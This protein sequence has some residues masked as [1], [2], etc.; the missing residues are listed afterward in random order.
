MSRQEVLRFF[1]G[2]RSFFDTTVQ[3]N[4]EK[5]RKGRCMVTVL[6]GDGNEIAGARV[7]IKQKS[8]AFRFGA[9]LFMLEELE[10]EEKNRLYKEYFKD[11]FNMATL[12]FYWTSIE[13]RQGEL[14]YEKNAQKYYRRPPI[15]LCMEFCQ[16]NGIEPREHGLAYE[17]HF[18]KWIKG[19]SVCEI[20]ELLEKRYA[21]IARRYAEKIPTIEVTNEMLW[22]EGVTDFYDCDDYVEWCFKTADKYF[23]NNRL[24]INENTE[25]CWRRIR[26]FT[27]PY[28]GYISS[29][30]KSGARIDAIG[31]QYHIFYDRHG[32]SEIA[33]SLYNPQSLYNYL[34]FFSRLVKD[35]QI[36]EIT[37]PAY[38]K[39]KDDEEIQAKIIEYLYTLWFSHPAVEQIVYW[40]LVD[41]YAYVPDPT[42][43]EIRR[44][45]GDMTVG[46]NVYHG[47]LLRFDLS[48]KPAYETIRRLVKEKWHTELEK[49]TN[50]EGSVDISGFYGD[51]DLEITVGEKTVKRQ[52]SISKNDQNDFKITI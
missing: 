37:I 16:E 10:T 20:K 51:Y 13:P 8:H 23:P 50:A 46:E 31:M 33:S 2:A 5:H 52:I 28:Y 29:A 11:V 22:W 35:L 9:N 49:D 44:T 27:N 36:T 47:G 34:D 4:I 24:V 17:Q 1:E 15:D 43:E 48:P 26:R 38:S 7:K 45:Q 39:E 25:D 14:R 19:K 30:I 32:E 12:P 18:P 3:E 40:N 21:E 42:P 41:G 6:D